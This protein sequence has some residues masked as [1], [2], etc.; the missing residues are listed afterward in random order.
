MW[1]NLLINPIL[2]IAVRPK[3]KYFQYFSIVL[4]A[5]AVSRHDGVIYKYVPNKYA[6]SSTA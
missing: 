1:D 3:Y 5:R 4:R 2:S 6:G